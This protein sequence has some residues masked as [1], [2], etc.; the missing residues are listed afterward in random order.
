MGAGD[1]LG[2]ELGDGLAKGVALLAIKLRAADA[3]PAARCDAFEGRVGCGPSDTRLLGG[4]NTLFDKAGLWG[5]V[6]E[7]EKA[8]PRRKTTSS[9]KKI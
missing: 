8:P 3:F 7:E 1:E 9:Q 5:T 4:T 6:S 2:G